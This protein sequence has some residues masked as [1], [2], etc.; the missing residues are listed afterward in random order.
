MV[1]GVGSE[2]RVIYLL[3]SHLCCC[4][5]LLVSVMELWSL[6]CLQAMERL[7]AMKQ[8]YKYKNTVSLAVVGLERA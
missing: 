5:R 1:G 7:Q 8:E 2:S 4:L 6:A 3:G